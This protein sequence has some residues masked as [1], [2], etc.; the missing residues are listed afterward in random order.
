M[1]DVVADLDNFPYHP[2]TTTLL[3]N[4]HTFHGNGISSTL[5]YIPNTLIFTFPWPNNVWTIDST[6]SSI[7][8]MTVPTATASTRTATLEPTIRQMADM[9]LFTGWRDETFPIYGLNGEVVLEI[10]RA[11]SAL[12]GIVTYGVQMLCYTEDST[13]VKLWIAKRSSQKQTYPGMLDTT[14]AGGIEYGDVTPGGDYAGSD[15]G[16]LHSDGGV[17]ERGKICG[18]DFVFSCQRGNEGGVLAA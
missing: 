5:G 3:Q 6:A 18:S 12:F 13:G 16:G 1:Y 10:E 9:Q 14:A 8:L 4:Y 2:T 7:T 15:G 11:A 17:G